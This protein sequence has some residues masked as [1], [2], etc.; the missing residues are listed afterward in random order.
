MRNMIVPALGVTMVLV[1]CTSTAPPPPLNGTT[2]L[3]QCACCTCS[4][5]N[6]VCPNCVLGQTTCASGGSLV[7]I[8]NSG[9]QQ[10][11][12]LAGTAFDQA[13]GDALCA[14][15]C[16]G[17]FLTTGT[18]DFQC[19]SFEP[20]SP[21][22]LVTCTVSHPSSPAFA[23]PGPNCNTNDPPGVP[24][25]TIG[26]GVPNSYVVTLGAGSAVETTDSISG[27]GNLF[28][29]GNSSAT[30][31]LAYTLEGGS[32][33]LN[34]LTISVA[35]FTID[36]VTSVSNLT[37]VN[38]GASTGTLT[39]GNTFS[40]P[41]GSVLVSLSGDTSTL[42]VSSTQ[43]AE[44]Y[45]SQTLS[46]TFNPA[47]S[48]NSFTLNGTFS[49]NDYGATCP[50]CPVTTMI[51]L[52]G[53]YTAFPP[54]AVA[55]GPYQ[56]DCSSPGQGIVHVDGSGS[57]DGNGATSSLVA[58]RWLEGNTQVGSGVM[59]DISLP[60]GTHQLDLRVFNAFGEYADSQATASVV[61]SQPPVIESVT[62]SQACI[63]P[64]NDKFL[65]YDLGDQIQ[66]QVQDVCYPNPTVTFV[67]GQVE[68]ISNWPGRGSHRAGPKE[69]LSLGP[70][71]F[72]V[73]AEEGNIY[74][75]DVQATNSA[76]LSSNIV[77][78]TIEVPTE[79]Q[80]LIEEALCRE[81]GHGGT[82]GG[83][84]GGSACIGDGEN[85]GD[86]NGGH[87]FDGP[88]GNGGF[89]GNN[90]QGNGGLGGNGGSCSNN[91]GQGKNG[92]CPNSGTG[93]SS[94]SGGGNGTG[95][96]AGQ[97]QCCSALPPSDFLPF[98][99][100]RC[101][102]GDAGIAVTYVD[103]GVSG[104]RPGPSCSTDGGADVSLLGLAA[105]CALILRG[106]HRE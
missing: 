4:E 35:S 26:G 24:P 15:T 92:S 16:G 59:A 25:G 42:G 91:N 69:D 20:E 9:P 75:V 104:N 106:R 48:V 95:N 61:D 43:G 45:N 76:G 54:N 21:C 17:T 38:E 1:A 73:R 41:A 70:T 60:V 100:P 97:S 10:Q 58:Y 63:W 23:T 98:G 79:E 7:C 22:G 47:A 93:G 28:A 5:V 34:L 46:G 18:N 64:P 86:G 40:F 72:C 27:P 78:T 102:F 31:T 56:A 62:D 53:A 3:C 71:A 90:G 80:H 65:L 6:G 44:V 77:T 85:G 67:G 83:N 55:G 29:A 50:T 99:D 103:A 74:T 94:G 30:G 57:T 84:S 81:T 87:G 101:D 68:E 82:S 49:S 19:T 13:A 66:V 52:Q 11:V 12:C 96:D 89:G 88:G 14:S 37:I 39:G 33:V 32:I 36:G 2:I 51:S 105:L 8:D